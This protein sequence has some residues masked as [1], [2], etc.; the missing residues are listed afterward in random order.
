[1]I[2]QILQ[3]VGILSAFMALVVF[4]VNTAYATAGSP[5]FSQVVSAGTWVGDI[6]DASYV[7]V[8]SPTVAMVG[9]PFSYTC[10][11]ATGTLGTATQQIYVSN[12]QHTTN[13]WSVTIAASAT[14][15]VWDNATTSDADYDFNDAGGSGCTDTA[16]TE[17]DAFGGQMTID[18][19]TNGTLAVG[20]DA[21]TS[22]TNV[23][24]GSSAA[25]D[26]TG[27]PVNSITLLSATA[28]ADDLGDWTL[29]GIDISQKI[30]AEQV[31]GTYGITLVIT[32]AH[33]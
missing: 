10:Q 13:A 9:V 27:T 16:E 29:Q 26:S 19:N 23:S 5:V 25:F 28:A 18:A 8:T 4:G 2:K 11:T 20:Q 7:S 22:L 15:A 3:I 1:M 33:I 32:F 30:P 14:T 17:A 12:P 21:D 24:K 31:L 6:V